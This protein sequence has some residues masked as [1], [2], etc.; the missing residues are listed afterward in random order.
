[1]N[2]KNFL[3]T[4]GTGIAAA[5]FMP[6]NL[7][8]KNKYEVEVPKQT[9]EV[10]FFEFIVRN[11]GGKHKIIPIGNHGY[12]VNINTS[13]IRIRVLLNASGTNTFLSN[14]KTFKIKGVPVHAGNYFSTNGFH[15]SI[16]DIPYN[17]FIKNV[18]DI[19]FDFEE[20]DIIQLCL[21]RQ[22][23]TN[24]SRLLASSKMNKSNQ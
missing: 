20:N 11:T 1:M 24:P 17:T 23:K 7:F 14:K 2:R 16:V 13:L 12:E 4:L 3:R 6:K 22:D 19:E 21:F 15:C 18:N 5:V 9:D 10:R 8:S